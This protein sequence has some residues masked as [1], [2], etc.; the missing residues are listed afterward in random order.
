MC[1]TVFKLIWGLALCYKRKVF[2]LWPDS[3]SWSFQLI[4]HCNIAVRI[5][6]L[7]RF[8]EIQKKHPFPI[9]K[10]CTSLDL[11]KAVNSSFNR[12]FTCCCSAVLA[13]RMK[14]SLLN[15]WPCL[16]HSNW[17]N[18]AF[19][20]VMQSHWEEN[21]KTLQQPDI[22]QSLSIYPVFSLWSLTGITLSPCYPILCRMYELKEYNL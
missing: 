6:D 19:L 3:G 1:S 4:Q 12:E 11:L 13:L 14:C 21:H 22:L 10:E 16:K 2:L 15:I 9:R 18:S 20:T 5:D 7:S 17:I 8:Q